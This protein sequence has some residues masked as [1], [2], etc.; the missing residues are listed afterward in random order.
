[1]THNLT[2]IGPNPAVVGVVPLPEGWPAANHTERDAALVD[3]KRES[4][5]YR[6]WRPEDGDTPRYDERTAPQTQQEAI[7]GVSPLDAEES[8][9]DAD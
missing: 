8:A 4:G 7:S 9:P 1:M 2:Y 3:E 6:T 5:A